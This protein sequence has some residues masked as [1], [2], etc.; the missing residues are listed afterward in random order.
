[1]RAI[2][3]R[4]ALKERNVRPVSQRL[5]CNLI[6][7]SEYTKFHSVALAGMN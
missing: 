4:N 6:A 1:M 5:H 2:A 3:V 7:T